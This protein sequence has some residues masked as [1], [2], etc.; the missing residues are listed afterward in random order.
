MYSNTLLSL[1]FQINN[2]EKYLAIQKPIITKLFSN[3]NGTL[4]IL[5]FLSFNAQCKNVGYHNTN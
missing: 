1:T 3:V 2:G 4:H 5:K